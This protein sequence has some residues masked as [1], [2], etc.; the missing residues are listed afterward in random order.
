V[1]IDRPKALFNADAKRAVADGERVGNSHSHGKFFCENHF[2]QINL[3]QICRKIGFSSFFL[4]RLGSYIRPLNKNERRQ[5]VRELKGPSPYF[6]TKFNKRS[7]TNM[8]LTMVL[9][10]RCAAIVGSLRAAASTVA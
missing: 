4:V 1:A 3:H 9:P 8:T 7:A 5:S 10:S 2:A 6:T